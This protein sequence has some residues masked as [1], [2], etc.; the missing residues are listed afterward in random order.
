MAERGAGTR[1]VALLGSPV[2]HSVSPQLHAAAFVAR[3]LDLAYLAFDVAPSALAVAVSGLG[4]LG[5]LGANVTVPHKVAALGLVGEA[6]DEA[7]LIGAVNTLVWREG[8]LRGDNTDAVG[9]RVV[10]HDDVALAA[11]DDV[12]LVGTGGAARAAAVA[13][14]RCGAVVEVVG[15]RADAVEEVAALVVTAGGAVDAALR[16]P[17]LVVNATPLGLGGEPLPERFLGLGRGQVALDMTYGRTPSP[18]VSSARETGAVGLDGLGMLIAQAAA[19]FSIW[20][21]LDAPVQ[22]MAEA[23]ARALGRTVET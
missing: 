17:R 14:G 10:L 2:A 7:V 16:H 19:S 18:F 8:R 15:R 5:A 20:T 11:G 6:S 12:V 23:G 13:L 1:L 9:L 3:G 22:V 21:G 4:A